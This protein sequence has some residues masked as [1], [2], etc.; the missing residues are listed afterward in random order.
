[1][2]KT[3]YRI[4]ILVMY[5]LVTLINSCSE[6]SEEEPSC[7]ECSD[8]NRVSPICRVTFLSGCNENRSTFCE[9][10]KPGYIEGAS[11]GQDNVRKC[12]STYAALTTTTITNIT[13]NGNS[14][15]ATSGGVITGDG[16][17]PVSK[18]GVCFSKA[19]IPLVLPTTTCADCII[20]TN[21]SGKGSFV[22]T[23][24]GLMRDSNYVVRA[25]ATNS[26]GTA[27]GN[28]L[29]FTANNGIF[30]PV[31]VT[32]PIANDYALNITAGGSIIGDGG[33]PITERGVC[34][35]TTANP[36]IAN[37]KLAAGAGTGLFTCQ[38]TLLNNSTY[39]LKAYA[40]NINGTY[41][42]NQVVFNTLP[43]NVPSLTTTAATGV[44]F[45]AATLGGNVTNNGGSAVTARGVC[46]ST[47]LNPTIADDKTLNGS[48]TGA[49]TSNLSGLTASTTYHVRAYATNSTGTGY[50]LDQTFTTAAPPI[51]A[52]TVT[53]TT[54]T[55]IT[56]TDAVSGGNVTSDGGA[57]VTAR[58]VCY[59]T[60][61][62]PT[63]ANFKTLDG[64]G[65]G[66]FS[67]NLIVL[68]PST[69]YHVRAYATNSI[70]TSYGSD[71]Q[72]TTAP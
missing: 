27:Y 61:P 49:F 16:G 39:Y 4:L 2:I 43:L 10:C 41:Y 58:G 65:T 28:A 9:P 6:K 37:S 18:R 53:T 64:S 13:I 19:T 22:S 44:T 7:I 71:L 30:S 57:T 24:N 67:S 48:G 3:D 50:G 42:G 29:T 36:T 70:G 23:L 8:P 46:Y 40:T 62:N 55:A 68:S 1:M 56:S 14:V 69:T 45:S 38:L 12:I 47:T 52:P 15:T 72:F 35:S 60:N 31:V 5:S 63:T 11:S 21:G 26:S 51:T 17:N 33:S 54:V 32:D 66:T 20:T 25:Y 59:S 34:W